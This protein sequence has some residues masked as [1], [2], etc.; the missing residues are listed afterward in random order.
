MITPVA[1]CSLEPEPQHSTWAVQWPSLS[2][3]DK[4]FPLF[5]LVS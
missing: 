2:N 1:Q 4:T 5:S 3:P